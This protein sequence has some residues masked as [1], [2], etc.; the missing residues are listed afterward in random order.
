MAQINGAKVEL[1]VTKEELAAEL[2]RLHDSGK[3]DLFNPNRKVSLAAVQERIL[4]R[5]RA[6]E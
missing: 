6:T 2:S 3:I 1:Q 4:A 5:K